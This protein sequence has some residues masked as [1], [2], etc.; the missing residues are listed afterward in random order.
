VYVIGIGIGSTRGVWDVLL[1][2]PLRERGLLGSVL[3]AFET[4]TQNEKAFHLFV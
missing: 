4:T 1:V 2:K 3:T